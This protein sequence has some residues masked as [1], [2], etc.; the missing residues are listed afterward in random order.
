MQFFQKNNDIK[1]IAGPCSAENREQILNTAKELSLLDKRIIFRAGVWKPRTRPNTF[2]GAGDIAL[3]W[4]NEVQ[5][6]LGLYVSTEVAEP[7]HVEKVLKAGIKIVWIGARTS[8]NPFSVQKIANALAGTGLSVMV[9]NPQ[10]PDVDLWIGNIERLL[11]NGINDIAAIHRGFFPYEKHAYRNIPKWEVPIE[12]KRRLPDLTI[13]CDPSHISGKRQYIHEISQRALDLDFNGLM[14]ETHINPAEALSDKNQQFNIKQFK[15]LLESLKWRRQ[16]AEDE[17]LSRLIDDIREK[18]D[19][20]DSQLLELL[21]LRMKYVDEIG[22]YKKEHNVSVFQ[23]KRWANILETRLKQAE[24]IGLP[25]DFVHKLLEMIHKESI[26]RQ[27]EILRN[28][29][30]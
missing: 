29:N 2:L 23:L 28:N 8:S 12:L 17:A 25:D 21:Q 1:L 13:F 20:V 9:K 15:E 27:S 24:S 3:N 30:N 22:N 4:L 5:K 16:V 6:K 7:E 26:R 18:I 14:I 10:Y 11:Q 19:C